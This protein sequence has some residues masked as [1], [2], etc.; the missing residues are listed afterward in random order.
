MLAFKAGNPVK[1]TR[2]DNLS[3]EIEKLEMPPLPVDE[4]LK[5]FALAR[6][7]DNKVILA[8]GAMMTKNGNQSAKVALLDV[9]KGS[10]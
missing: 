6:V 4:D 8:G 10:W 1:V 9:V 2:Y 7:G 3:G 5:D